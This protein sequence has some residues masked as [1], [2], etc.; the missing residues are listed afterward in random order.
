MFT[1]FFEHQHN[2]AQDWAPKTI[3]IH[4]LKNT[5]YKNNVLLEPPTSPK[6]SVLQVV[7]F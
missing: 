5:G 7:F 4:I 2:F 3:T 1:A 6:I